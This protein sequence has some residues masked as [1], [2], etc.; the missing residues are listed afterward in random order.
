MLHLQRSRFFNY[1]HPSGST[2]QYSE[3]P[4]MFKIIKLIMKKQMLT[5]VAPL[6][7]RLVVLT[8]AL[9]AFSFTTFAQGDLLIMPKRVMF[10]G[11]K[12]S[13]DLN[14]ANIGRDS[15]TYVIS[16]VQIRMKED[17]TFERIAVP[18]SGQNFSDKN[19]RFFPR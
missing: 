2:I 12:R 13:E 15:A 16:I 5:S 4:P 9:L 19:I 11:A 1:K 8:C 10:E 17:G 14:L 18:D 7:V 3:I 6:R